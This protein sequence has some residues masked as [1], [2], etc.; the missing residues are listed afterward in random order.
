MWHNILGVGFADWGLSG[1]E[2]RYLIGD[3]IKYGDVRFRSNKNRHTIHVLIVWYLR[4]RN[5]VGRG[6]TID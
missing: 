6:R 4:F 2:G 5:K 1:L 3:Y